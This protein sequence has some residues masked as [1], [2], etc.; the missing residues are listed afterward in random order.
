MYSFKR[1]KEIYK[2]ATFKS[3]LW[4]HIL[5]TPRKWCRI[6]YC[7]YMC[8]RYPFL[9]PR[10]RWSGKHYNNWTILNYAGRIY[11]KYCH[12]QF[13]K[14]EI[15][16]RTEITS[17]ER[18]YPYYVERASERIIKGWKNWWAKPYWRLISFFHDYVLQV[19]HCLPTSTEWDAV[20]PGWKKAF[21]KQYLKDLK[22]QLKKDKCLYTWRITNIKEK[23]GRFQLYCNWGSEELYDLIEKYEEL[24]WNTCIKCGKPATHTSR[25]WILPYCEE[26]AKNVGGYG[27]IERG[28]KEENESYE[29]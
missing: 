16:T 5:Y 22:K 9:Y 4:N 28:T 6:P 7:T 10:N 13:S 23:W 26:C 15:L 18:S 24:S 27:C 1:Y 3:Y 19:F 11:S 8:I 14:E 20:E 12:T 25:G 17:F 29:L 2:N 21:G